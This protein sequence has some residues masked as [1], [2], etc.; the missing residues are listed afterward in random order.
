[1]LFIIRLILIMLSLFLMSIYAIFYCLFSPRNPKNTYHFAMLFSKMSHLVGLKVQ[2]R[3]PES[4]KSNGSVVYI[5]NHQNNCDMLTTTG[6]VQP[7]SVTIG[8]KSLVWIPFFGLIYW[9]TGNIL[10][11]RDNKNKS[12]NTISDVVEQMRAK[13]LAVWIFPEGTRSRGRGLMPFKMGAF[14]TALQAGVNVVPTVVS[15]THKQVK[16]NRWDNGEVIVEMLEPIDISQYKKREIRRLMNDAH[17]IMLEKYEQ[18]NKEA[19]RPDCSHN[20]CG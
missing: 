14:H 13:D 7:G 19:K 1:M 4:A 5:A 20:C 2:V 12:K 17:A 11:D 8:K 10:I 3:I 15:N 16:L 18:L 9:L 6:A